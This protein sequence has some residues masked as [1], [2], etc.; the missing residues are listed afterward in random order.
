MKKNIQAMFLASGIILTWC[1]NKKEDVPK[2][3]IGSKVIISDIS[4]KTDSIIKNEYFFNI[5]QK[6]LNEKWEVE[7]SFNPLLIFHPIW[8]E[9][10]TVNKNHNFE[11][12]NTYNSWSNYLESNISYNK[13]NEAKTQDC[14]NINKIK[15]EDCKTKIVIN[16][17]TKSWSASK[18]YFPWQDKLLDWTTDKND[19]KNSEIAKERAEDVLKDLIRDLEIKNYSVENLEKVVLDT[20]IKTFSNDELILL[21]K[22]WKKFD[23]TENYKVS[24]WEKVNELIWNIHNLIHLHKNNPKFVKEVLWEKDFNILS[25]ILDSKRMSKIEINYDIVKH[26]I[27]LSN[28]NYL[29]NPI[30]LFILISIIR[31]AIKNKKQKK[32]NSN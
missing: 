18:E 21:D 1:D 14:K 17:W 11:R 24:Y 13:I 19:S 27:W 23:F 8:I 28:W 4:S 10:V 32:E 9:K 2:E 29:L 7:S 3:E 5:Y 12:T 20:E 30:S 25:E 6:K 26:E 22:F 31:I 15:E 16:Y